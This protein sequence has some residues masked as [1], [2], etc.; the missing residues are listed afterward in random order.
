M[1]TLPPP[2]VNEFPPDSLEKQVY[3]LVDLFSEY[4]P[5]PNDRNRLSYSLFK[6][7]TGEG[8]PALV[9]IKAAKV[10]LKGI[11]IEDLA[12][13]LEAGIQAIKK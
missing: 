12:N 3:N 9:S 8:D 2:A 1:S 11:A 7:M 4:L 5:V 6:Y 13:K 10:T